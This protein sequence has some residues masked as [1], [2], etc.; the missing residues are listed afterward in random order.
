MRNQAQNMVGQKKQ[1]YDT[2]VKVFG[3]VSTIEEQ[4]SMTS[5]SDAP[6]YRSGLLQFSIIETKINQLKNMLTERDSKIKRL[7]AQV[8]EKS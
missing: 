2:P 7:E 5:R 6:S 4:K 1:L 3:D 8:N